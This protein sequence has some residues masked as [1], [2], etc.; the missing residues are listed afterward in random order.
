MIELPFAIDDEALFPFPAIA[1]S[2]ASARNVV[3]GYLT[4]HHLAHMEMDLLIAVGEVMQNI[5]RYGFEGGDEKGRFA[6]GITVIDQ[7]I[8]V[9]LKDNAPPSDPASWSSAERKPEEGGHGL[10]LV[11]QIAEKAHFMALED[12]NQAQLLFA[13]CAK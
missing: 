12:G 9:T 8:L 4:A 3:R 7:H 10:A 2:L 6:I 5:I 1:G 11:H 13:V